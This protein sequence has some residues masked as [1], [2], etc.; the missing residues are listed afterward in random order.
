MPS[1]R[2]D[3]RKKEKGTKLTKYSFEKKVKK[4][5]R[6]NPPTKIKELKKVK[7]LKPKE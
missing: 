6:I 7:T 1:K 5:I 2:M 4:G 3:G